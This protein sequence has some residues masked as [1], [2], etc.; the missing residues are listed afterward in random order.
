[1]SWLV[2]WDHPNGYADDI[3]FQQ[4]AIL[5]TEVNH[6]RIAIH[7]PFVAVRRPTIASAASQAVCTNAAR[8]NARIH[9]AQLARPYSIHPHMMV[10]VCACL[11]DPVVQYEIDY[12]TQRSDCAPP[13]PLGCEAYADA[14]RCASG[15]RRRGQVS[16][17]HRRVWKTVSARTFSCDLVR[18]L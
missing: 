4:A 3:L 14:C 6:L 16:R 10:G 18:C 2:K 1:M 7:R 11:W 8:A 15:V 9:A 5:R 12:R 13:G 17:H